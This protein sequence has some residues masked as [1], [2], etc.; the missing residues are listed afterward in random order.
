MKEFFLRV[1][2]SRWAWSFSKGY[3]ISHEELFDMD[4]RYDYKEIEK[5]L[6]L[7]QINFDMN[8]EGIQINSWNYE[9]FY[10]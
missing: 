9:S 6:K 5:A 10:Y 7:K 3:F 2:G 1:L 8:K 4:N